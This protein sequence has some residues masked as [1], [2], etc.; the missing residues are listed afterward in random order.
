MKHLKV[1]RKFSRE[2]KQRE[3]MLKTMLGDLLVKRKMNTTLAKAKELKSIAEKA[4]GQLKKAPSFRVAK[5]RL[6][7]NVTPAILKEIIEKTASRNSG[8]TRITKR[9]RR[10]SDSAEMA[11]IEIIED[12]P[13]PVAEDKKTDKK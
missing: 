3:A 2:K 5:S 8:Y 7:K 11:K 9:G 12:A 10:L 6:P 4:I 13:K 1:G